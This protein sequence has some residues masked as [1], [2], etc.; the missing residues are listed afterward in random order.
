[1]LLLIVN[2]YS[3]LFASFL[4]V[5]LLMWRINLYWQTHDERPSLDRVYIKI[6]L[7]TVLGWLVGAALLPLRA[8][9]G[10]ILS[11][12]AKLFVSGFAVPCVCLTLLGFAAF[13]DR[14]NERK[15]HETSH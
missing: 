13:W 12:G 6:T 11:L 2:L 10:K 4:G 1:M 14:A 15:K 7:F 3:Y 8:Y 9:D 5:M